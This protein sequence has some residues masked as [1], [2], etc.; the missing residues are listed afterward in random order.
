MTKMLGLAVLIATARRR[1][2]WRQRERAALVRLLD[3]IGHW[4][5]LDVFVVV[6]LT[7]MVRFEPLAG[8]TPEPGLFAFGAVVV[9]TMLATDGFD[10]RLI[11]PRH[12]RR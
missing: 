8:V 4:S 7:G 3:A 5:M 2:T 12:G 6:L 1:S 11:W 10:R 9:L